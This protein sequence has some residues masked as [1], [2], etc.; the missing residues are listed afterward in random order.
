MRPSRVRS[1]RS[2]SQKETIRLPKSLLMGTDWFHY[3]FT[4][5]DHER[6]LSRHP[7]GAISPPE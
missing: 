3:Q 6:Q 7:S 1:A 2:R 5:S 4:P